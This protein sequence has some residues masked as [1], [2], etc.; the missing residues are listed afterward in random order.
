MRTVL[1]GPEP[2]DLPHIH[3]HTTDLAAFL[4]GLVRR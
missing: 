2:V 4:A 1:V 3:P